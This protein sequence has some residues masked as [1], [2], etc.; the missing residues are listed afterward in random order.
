MTS[1][2]VKRQP[3]TYNRVAG[4]ASGQVLA[5][6]APTSAS[7]TGEMAGIIYAGAP[8][9]VGTRPSCCSICSSS[10]TCQCSAMRP[11]RIL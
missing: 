7:V 9:G 8:S 1:A 2:A 10:T 3:Q 11:S 4:V 6:R 5:T